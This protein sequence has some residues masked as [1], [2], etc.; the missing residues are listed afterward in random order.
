MQGAARGRLRGGDG[1]EEGRRTLQLRVRTAARGPGGCGGSIS[2]RRTQVCE[3]PSGLPRI[4]GRGTGRI[5]SKDRA[6]G[7]APEAGVPTLHPEVA[8]RPTPTLPRGAGASWGSSLASG[9]RSDEP[10]PRPLAGLTE[11]TR[12]RCPAD[13]WRPGKL[14]P[15]VRSSF[16]RLAP[17][18]VDRGRPHLSGPRC[19]PSDSRGCPWDRHPVL[20]PPPARPDRDHLRHLTRVSGRL[21]SSSERWRMARDAVG[22]LS[23]GGA[24]AGRQG[25]SR[26][27]TGSTRA[28]RNGELGRRRATRGSNPGS[29]RP[30]PGEGAQSDL[31]SSHL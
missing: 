16:S 18:A 17:S 1:G 24:G 2:R 14:Q 26:P 21:A 31:S 6:G 10:V 22:K 28:G 27:G 4:P 15:F 23:R 20:P 25:R 7:A 13:A 30:E 12:G 19:P 3:W 29:A 5:A 8:Q 11:L 9:R